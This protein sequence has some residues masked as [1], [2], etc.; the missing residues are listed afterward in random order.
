MSSTVDG[1]GT[2]LYYDGAD[3]APVCGHLFIAAGDP[4]AERLGLGAV[5]LRYAALGL[6]VFPLQPEANSPSRAA[7][8]SRTRRPTRRRSGLGGQEDGAG[9]SASPPGSAVGCS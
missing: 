1:T 9:T 4:V 6:A 2:P 5:A 7:T 3:P 8:R